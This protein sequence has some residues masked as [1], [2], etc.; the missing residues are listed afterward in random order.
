MQRH[1]KEVDVRTR[2]VA[3]F[4]RILGEAEMRRFVI[5][6][7]LP[8]VQRLAG[9][10]IWQVNST[11]VGG[12]VAEML[13]PLVGYARGAGIDAR[14]VTIG[15]SPEFFRITKRLHHALHG[16]RG[17]GSDF[18]DTERQVYEETL[19]RNA[20]E[21]C[22]RVQ[23]RDIVMLHDP[24]T[25]GLAPALARQGN[26]VIWRCH[27]GRD[28]PNEE[29]ERAWRFLLPYLQHVKAYVFSRPAYVPEFCDHGKATIIQPSIDAFSV[30][31]REL[32]ETKI[33]TIL[34]HVGLVEGPPPPS[35]DHGFERDDGTPARVEHRADVIRLGRAP[36]WETPLVVQVSR[37][38]PLKDPVGVMRGFARLLERGERLGGAELVLAGPNVKAVADDPEGAVVLEEVMAAWR[39]LPHSVRDRIHLASLPT[40]DVDENAVIVNA[41]QR[42]AHVIV[43]KS[44]QEGFGLTVTEAMWKRRPVVASAVGG[45]RDQIE[46]G[47]SGILLDDPTDLERFGAALKQVIND[48]DYA[49]RLG[50]G[51]CE[52]IRQHF[53]GVRHLQQY[54]ELIARLDS[55][56]GTRHSIAGRRRPRRQAVRNP[57]E[58][59]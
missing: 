41:L 24:Q 56:E 29:V 19:R 46:N 27:V 4:A 43:Q 34:V 50:E 6:V 45:I 9:R 44:L 31:N 22:S 18:G 12:G 49:H 7:S 30:K 51:A 55:G 52:R 14:W 25:A 36:T 11:A 1:L 40:R 13:R 53:L 20:A 47:V 32:D 8:M 42:H 21:L 10:V 54:A 26:L 58:R 59:R 3:Q 39:R 17:D 37:W 28:T 15:G 2:S 5:D 35:P 48:R 23:P 38:D 33:R 16:T 57:Y